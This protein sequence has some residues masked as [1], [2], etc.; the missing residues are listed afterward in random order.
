MEWY[1]A[2]GIREALK[3]NQISEE[4]AEALLRDHSSQ[5]RIITATQHDRWASPVDEGAAIVQDGV[6]QPV[7]QP[8][9]PITTT[10]AA[11]ELVGGRH[12]LFN[13]I[14]RVTEVAC[15]FRVKIVEWQ[16]GTLEKVQ[17]KKFIA[18]GEWYTWTDK[19]GNVRRTRDE[20]HSGSERFVKDDNG[21]IHQYGAATGL[22]ARLLEVAALVPSSAGTHALAEG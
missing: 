7:S 16:D 13:R 12:P 19:D 4:R 6:S 1:E 3:H 2:A 10:P 5:L 20:T 11:G 22:L 14:Q 18:Y 17:A 21:V 15:E 9:T 8:L